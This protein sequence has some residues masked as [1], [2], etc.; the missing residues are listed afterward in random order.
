MSDAPRT[1]A[2]QLRSWSDEQLARL[3]SARPDLAV[4][5]P[6]DTSQLA[7]R[8]GVRASVI[9]AL[10]QC[11]LVDLAV[12]DLLAQLGGTAAREQLHKANANAP[13][14]DAAI[15]R[16]HAAAL[17]WGSDDVRAP[18]G[19][20]EV[21]REMSDRIAAVIERGPVDVPPRLATSRRDATLVDRAAAGAAFEAV[22]LVE[23]LLDHWG[24]QPPP[25]LRA[26][27]LGVR[28]LKAA[29]TLLHSDERTT[30]LLIETARAAG[31][32]ASGHTPDADASWLPTETFDHWL[33]ASPA[34]RWARLAIAWLGNPR[35]TGVIGSR[36]QGKTVNALSAEL[37]RSWLAL[38]RREALDQ[39]AELPPGDVL[40]SGT[41]VVSLVDR[42]RW[43]RPRRPAARAE[44]VAWAI[45]E[46]A[47]IGV[48]GLGGLSTHGRALL[49][50]DPMH[51]A[52]LALQPLLPSTVD[53]VVVQ[54]DLTAVAGGPLAQELA[55]DL[56]LLA[57]V[58]SRG[59][60][61]V[62]R[63]TEAS[64][65]RG[66][67]AGWSTGEVIEFLSGIADNDLPQPLTYLVDDV[68]RR[69]G[70]VRAGTAE[71]FLRSDDEVALTELVHQATSLRLR[72]IAPTVVVSD[73]PLD[74]L[75][76]RLRALG[77]A[78]VVEAPD[79]TVQIA[80]REVHRARVAHKAPVET[81]RSIAQVSKVVAAIRAGDRATDSRPVESRKTAP[82]SVLATLRQTVEA[83]GSVWISYVDN[84]GSLMERVV[85]P[86]RVDSGWLAAYDHRSEGDRSFAIHRIVAVGPVTDP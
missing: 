17:V 19:V 16:L 78:P 57:D 33:A 67:D 84:D 45:E 79:G 52:P 15:E 71:S 50:D 44:A 31:L 60:A 58:D 86:Q 53:K 23:L 66:F 77:L 8:A 70:T 9:R 62:Y 82:A 63:F 5:P 72:R 6:Q 56:A 39:L 11:N 61:T 36:D 35:L 41:G 3:L 27:G 20:V 51:A 10:D 64:V 37:E 49:A 40:A 26:G 4:P 46:A 76:P 48:V 1:L 47:A 54:A 55:R 7:T 59:G 12:L 14:I 25:A 28:D 21:V 75:L 29:A 83:G 22:R 74:V 42:L 32:L 2:D 65:R 80:R 13:A 68:S 43:H 18:F 69:F 38:T 24:T 81:A 34:D 85:D 73:M 30:A